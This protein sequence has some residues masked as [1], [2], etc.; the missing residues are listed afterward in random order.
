MHVSTTRRWS[1]ATVA[2][3]IIL[4]AATSQT[5]KLAIQGASGAAAT[6]VEYGNSGARVH[7]ML[8]TK[9]QHKTK[10]HDA[11]EGFFFLSFFS[12]SSSSFFFAFSVGL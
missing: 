4:F 10:Q 1:N 12:F 6:N 2:N 3:T 11:W 9:E 7:A 8:Q 5:M